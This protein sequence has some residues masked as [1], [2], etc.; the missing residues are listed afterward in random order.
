MT[1][2]C[3]IRIGTS[4]WCYPHWKQRFYPAGLAQRQWLEY[5]SRVFNTVE[6]NNTFYHLPRESSVANWYDQTPADF[7]FTVKASRYIT[8]I[9]R[10]KDC[11]ESLDL[12]YD[13]ISSLKEKLAVVL[14][15]LPPNFGKNLTR[16][17]DFLGIL[18][19]DHLSVFEFRNVSWYCDD[20][21]NLLKAYNCGFC[22]HDLG[23]LSTPK[24]VTGKSMYLRLHGTTGKYRG[25][26][27]ESML[28][29]WAVW[30]EHQQ[31]NCVKAFVYFNNDINGYAVKNAETLKVDL[32]KQKPVQKTV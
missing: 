8:H 29:K 15:Q 4:G 20:T 11:R 2:I 10:L 19:A 9:K 1:R 27:S 18:P 25:K 5:Y 30:I 32:G 13:R 24:I 14:Y 16:L 22:I 3:D 12:F 26:Y 28:K 7:L 23:E 31:V 17:E 21:S 6:V